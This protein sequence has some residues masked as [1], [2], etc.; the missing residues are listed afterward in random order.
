M[1][2]NPYDDLL[3]NLLKLLEQVTS[4]EHHMHKLQDDE[5]KKPGIIGCAIIT[6]TTLGN[7]YQNEGGTNKPDVLPYEMIDAGDL[8]FLTIQLPTGVTEEPQVNFQV[9]Q[10]NIRAGRLSGT[11]VLKFMV[12]PEVSTWSYHNGVLDIVLKKTPPEAPVI[13]ESNPD[14]KNPEDNTVES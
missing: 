11:I 1:P 13:S 9:D 8:A 12:I 6:G 14:D 10:C 5:G 2:N 3:K 4:L 7:G